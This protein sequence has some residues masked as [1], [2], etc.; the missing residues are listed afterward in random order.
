MTFPQVN[1]EPRNHCPDQ[2]VAQNILCTTS[3]ADG[4]NSFQKLR[5]RYHSG[6][7]NGAKYFH[8]YKL[9]NTSAVHLHMKMRAW[10]YAS[11]EQLGENPRM[12]CAVSV[13]KWSWM[14]RSCTDTQT[15][16]VCN[17]LFDKVD[18]HA[19]DRLKTL[20]WESA[21]MF[22][23]DS[24][25][26]ESCSFSFFGNFLWQQWD[27]LSDLASFRSIHLR[28]WCHLLFLFSKAKF[29]SSEGV[30]Q[31]FG[32]TLLQNFCQVLWS[33]WCIV[34]ILIKRVTCP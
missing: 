25:D 14:Q 4:Q 16:S 27:P 21:K 29:E 6:A 30:E 15:K 31:Y 17:F 22:V 34:Y 9:F 11:D 3:E 10:I 1:Q 20:C 33:I 32:E 26:T 12:H 7:T 19:E 24:A 13:V 23:V 5:S 8:W 2:S 28:P 18:G